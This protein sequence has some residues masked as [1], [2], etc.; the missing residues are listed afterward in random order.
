MVTMFC[1][2]NGES[3]RSITE[4]SLPPMDHKFSIRKQ[5]SVFYKSIAGKKEHNN[6]FIEHSQDRY[7]ACTI[8]LNNAPVYTSVL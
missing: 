8:Y 6:I 3:M 2:R 4:I 5:L 7:A 1:T